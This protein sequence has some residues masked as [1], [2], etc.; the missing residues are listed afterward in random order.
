MTNILLI[1]ITLAVLV[2]FHELGHF[3]VAKCLGVGVKTFSLGFG[4]K[5][6]SCTLG[7]T[8]Y[9]LSL[10]PLGGY[11]SFYEP[12]VK[13]GEETA[14]VAEVQ[15]DRSFDNASL[16]KR[17]V[18]V[19]AGPLWNFL[20]AFVICWGLFWVNGMTIVVPEVAYVEVDSP[21]EEA[22]ILVG[23][24]VI[25][26]NGSE[27]VSW[28]D[29][30]NTVQSSI[31][32]PLAITVLRDGEEIALELVP[33]QRLKIGKDGSPLARGHVGFAPTGVHEKI[34]LSFMHAAMH[35]AAFTWEIVAETGKAFGL[36]VTGHLPSDA[37]GGPIMISQ[38][39]TEH[40]ERGASVLFALIAIISVNL[41]LVNLLP[42]PVLDGGHILMFIIEGVRGKPVSEA[43]QKNFQRVGLFALLLLMV[44]GT[45]NDIMRLW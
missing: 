40:A 30:V 23:D 15:K 2:F 34:E 39:I 5:L 38:A 13:N 10:V 43:M 42:L 17:I 21:A 3:L 14:I 8:E 44:W 33:V 1:I 24:R 19:A 37:I 4:P 27:E 6:L 16:P 29:I 35:G 20:L 18:I 25:A 36:L 32:K 28:G 22:G 7:E 31:G 26:F 12:P 11:V 45:Y 9:R 41:G